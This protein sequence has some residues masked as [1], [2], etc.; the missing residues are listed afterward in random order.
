MFKKRKFIS[1]FTMLAVLLIAA[2]MPVAF[3]AAAQTS[4]TAA[5]QSA[6]DC[7]TEPVTLNAYFE[8]LKF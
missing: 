1:T 5:L 6:P 4:N 2:Q 7:G 3:I 8:T